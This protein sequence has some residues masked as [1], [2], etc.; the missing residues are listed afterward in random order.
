MTEGGGGPQGAA[1]PTSVERGAGV[2]AQRVVGQLEV[3]ALAHQVPER[4][5]ALP[6][7]RRGRREAALEQR[8]GGGEVVVV[9]RLQRGFDVL[10]G[11]AERGEPALDAVRPPAVEAAPVLGEAAGERRVV[12]V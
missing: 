3:V 2:T 11:D 4:A 1:V 6:G 7:R 5:I 8:D 10:P 12:D 9:A